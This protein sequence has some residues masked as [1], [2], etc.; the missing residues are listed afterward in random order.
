MNDTPKIELVDEQWQVTLPGQDEPYRV[1]SW[2]PPRLL[3]SRGHEVRT[4]FLAANADELWIGGPD[5]TEKVVRRS[6]HDTT[7]GGGVMP[8]GDLSSPM[9]G[10]VLEVLVAEGDPV[11]AGDRLLILEAMKME[12]PIRAPHA[13][14]VARVHVSAGDSI[15]AGDPLIEVEATDVEPIDSE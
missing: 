11:E 14:V 6:A 8:A 3:L 15:G 4:F 12:S 1:V 2:Q 7:E 5:G 9:P 13:G 10:K